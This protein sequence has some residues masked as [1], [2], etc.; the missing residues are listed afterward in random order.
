[1]KTDE[2][3]SVDVIVVGA[4]RTETKVWESGYS[5]GIFDFAPIY[6]PLF[7][8]AGQMCEV[9]LLGAVLVKVTGPAEI[10]VILGHGPNKISVYLGRAWFIDDDD[11]HVVDTFH[12]H[13]DECYQCRTQPFNLCAVGEVLLKATASERELYLER[14]T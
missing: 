9:R 1:M 5:E 10:A 4:D 8:A 6:E 7:L 3:R 14:K 13:L 12:V 11:A 2:T